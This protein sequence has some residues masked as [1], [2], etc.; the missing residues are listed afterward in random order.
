M[1]KTGWEGMD[2]NAIGKI[3][4]PLSKAEDRLKDALKIARRRGADVTDLQNWFIAVSDYALAKNERDEEALRNVSARLKQL[5]AGLKKLE[6][7]AKF[8][9]LLI[10]Q[11]LQQG[12][13]RGGEAPPRGRRSGSGGPRKKR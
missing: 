12:K 1:E 3:I 9:G 13:D 5:E 6:A 7:V 2:W 8:D 11:A 4:G 10:G